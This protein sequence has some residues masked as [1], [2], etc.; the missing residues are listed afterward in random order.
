MPPHTLP[1]C[2]GKCLLCLGEYLKHQLCPLGWQEV[3]PSGPVLTCLTQVIEMFGI[4]SARGAESHHDDSSLL[5]LHTLEP[6]LVQCLEGRS[7]DLFDRPTLH[8]VQHT[9]NVTLIPSDKVFVSITCVGTR[10]G[11]DDV[12]DG[13]LLRRSIPIC[14]SLSFV[15]MLAI[16]QS[17][18]VNSGFSAKNC[19]RILTASPPTDRDTCDS[20]DLAHS[21]VLGRSD[22]KRVDICVFTGDTLVSMCV[23]H[24]ISSHSPY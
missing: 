21:I 3:K 20:V 10:V 9:V 19:D 11:P 8:F 7:L 17:R 12:D 2:L 5:F 22:S 16:C 18:V 24:C 13:R 15:R 14:V 1:P 23:P 6:S 4:F